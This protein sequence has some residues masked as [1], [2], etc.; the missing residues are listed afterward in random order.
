MTAVVADVDAASYIRSRN[1]GQRVGHAVARISRCCDLAD[2]DVPERQNSASLTEPVRVCSI[3]PAY[4]AAG[5]VADVVR[6]LLDGARQRDCE[7]PI[8]VVDDG[9]TDQTS[10]AARQA[11][12]EVLRHD[13]NRG[14]GQALKTGLDWAEAG[15][16]HA[17]VTLDADGQHPAEEALR[18]AFCPLPCDC[19][20]LGVR[21]LRLAHAPMSHRMSNAISNRF[22]S[23]FSGV[24][25]LD[26][27]C[28]LRRYPVGLW[29]ALNVRDSG[30]AFEAEILLRAVWR[31]T[32]IEQLP[33]SVHYPP[34]IHRV[35]HFDSVRD[36][37]R[38]VRRVVM[39][40]WERSRR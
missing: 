20:L 39:T 28:G 38:I 26:T 37:A 29:S 27:Q 32:R 30:Y 18:L 31:G 6:G 22:L 17:A 36:P 7:L 4:Q 35:S 3:I 23:W 9:S 25:L 11:G 2:A 33:V 10:I 1:I 19:L 15:G 21:D 13:Q 24:R 5:Q 14:K 40:L 16:Y 8:L 12:A 34:R